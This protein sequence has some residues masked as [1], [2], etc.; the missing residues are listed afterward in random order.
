[1]LEGRCNCGAIHFRVTAPPEGASVCHCS[2]CRRQSGHLWASAFVPTRSLEI[3]G[4][5][6]WY[7]ASETAR[8]GFC[9]TCGAFLFWKAH[10][11]DTVSFALGAL[12]SPTG[13]RLAKHIFVEDKGD[14]YDIADDVPRNP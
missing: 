3:F 4:K 11:E 2:Q 12:E 6:T 7:E 13:L 8:R 10:A 14:Y 1:M 9:G 5:P